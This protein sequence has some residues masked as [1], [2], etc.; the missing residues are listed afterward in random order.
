MSALLYVRVTVVD[1]ES[2]GDSSSAA[3]A[4]KKSQR[5]DEGLY[6]ELCGMWLNGPTQWADHKLGKKHKKNVR[7]ASKP[8]HR[9]TSK[10]IVIPETTAKVIEQTAIWNDAV[11]RYVSNLYLR[12]LSRL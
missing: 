7:R 12:A 5:K 6:C 11:M 10:G 8:K 4:A 9:R 1:T 2:H 3:M